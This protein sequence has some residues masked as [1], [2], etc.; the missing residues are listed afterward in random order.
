MRLRA[1]LRADLAQARKA[2]HSEKVTLIRTLIAALDNAEA[3]NVQTSAVA[4]SPGEVPRRTLSNEEIMEIVLRE[5]AELRAA[6][7]DYERHGRPDEANRLR[8][9]SRVADRY[10]EMS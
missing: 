9:L 5:G 10:A 2:N 3:V 4:D 7:E 8:S 1:I 6:A